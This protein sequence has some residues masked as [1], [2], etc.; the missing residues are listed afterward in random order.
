MVNPAQVAVPRNASRRILGA[1]RAIAA[2]EGAGRITIDAVAREA[3]LSKGG[4]LYNYPTKQALLSGLLEE[5][6]AEH[7]ELLEAVPEA[8]RV[9]TLRGHL[10]T[11]LR[12]ADGD[13]DLAMAI[14][15]TAA[16]DPA[17]LDPLRAELTGDLERIR[18][19]TQ[20]GAGA[21]VVM[22]AIQGLR[23]QR[24]LKLPDGGADL[25]ERAIARLRTLI[26]EL[27]Q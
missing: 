16:S 2:R 13:D 24:L 18:S 7:R 14:L 6:L 3:G 1:A 25:R 19:Q 27:D 9:R 4:V 26:D 15:A 10:D 20:D 11:V 5:M 8:Q 12:S 17:L 21:M 23:F 22:L